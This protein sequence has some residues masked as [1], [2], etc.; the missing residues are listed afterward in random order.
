MQASSMSV[1]SQRSRWLRW[2]SWLLIG[3]LAFVVIGLGAALIYQG[4][5]TAADL[6]A[7][8]PPGELIDVGGFRLHLVCMGEGSPTV[9]LD[10]LGDGTSANWGWVQP[11]VAKQT[12]VCAYDRAGRGWSE[13][14]PAPR[15]ARTMA[16]E[17][18]TLLANAGID[19]PKILV[20]HSFGAMVGRLYTDLY[21]DEVVGLVW[22][23][24]GFPDIYSD[25]MPQ[26][27]HEQAA[28][29]RELM[30][31]APL[32]ARLGIFRLIRRQ[33]TLP[34][35]QRSYAQ[36]FYG[37]NAL[38]DSLL[39][40]SQV[41]PESQR[42]WEEAD[43]FGDRPFMIVSAT[44]GWIDPNS[45]MDESRRIY[46]QMQEELLALSSNH[47]LRVV[48]G[49]SHASIVMAEEYA[50]QTSAAI[51]AVIEAVRNNRLLQ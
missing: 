6:R 28:A 8:P 51:V 39:T 34:E 1:Q 30:A 10:A 25:R 36:A 48:E 23:E 12:R 37:S 15:D 40:E 44:Q 49:A 46:N 5:A 27:A 26:A 35:P 9:I 29:D 21:P 18:H 4:V 17:L 2:L 20:G 24:P 45:P 3:L 41:L 33:E 31:M 16:Q 43:N 19:G 47:A 7:Y 50:A 11:E 42:Q 22:V 32:M 38:W 14:S 13:A